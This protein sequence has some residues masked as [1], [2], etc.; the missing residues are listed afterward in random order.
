VKAKWLSCVAVGVL[1]TGVSAYAHH[2]FTATYD[3][4]KTIQIEGTL[5]QFM[6]RN[7]HAFVHV[8]APD[9]SGEMQRWGV[10]WGGAGALAGQGVTRDSLK[11]GDHVI[12][13]GNPGRNPIDHRIRMRSLRRPSDNFGWGF[14]GETF[15]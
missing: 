10:E 2:S 1:L 5:V 4:S 7:P 14:Q 9:D 15:D 8:M 12:I 11:A 3:E 13:T 6:F